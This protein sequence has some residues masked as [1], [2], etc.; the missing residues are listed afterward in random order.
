MQEDE[1]II[2]LIEYIK[3]SPNREKVVRILDN[4][5]LKPTDISKKA[6]I[7]VNTVSKSLKQLKTHELV[8]LLNPD[9]KRGRLYKLTKKGNEVLSHMK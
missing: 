5:I 1:E 7:H 2:I 8:T 4:E 9:K 3:T 6:N